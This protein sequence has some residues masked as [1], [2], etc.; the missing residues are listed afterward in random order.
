MQQTVS[1]QDSQYGKM[2]QELSA[3]TEAKISRPSSKRSQAS[4]KKEYMFLDL[5]S[6][7]QGGAWSA[8]VGVL[9]GGSMT[10]NTGECPSVVVEST[11]SQIL[12][13]NAPRR[14]ALSVKACEGILRRSRKRG[15]D[16][17]TMLLTALEQ[18]IARGQNDTDG[19]T[20]L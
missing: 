7:E 13:E 18:Q 14:Y 9:P 3:A 17:P 10:L 11:L 12:V 16:L 20:I 4:A 6:G 1:I 8:M 19:E 2:S 5:R 15:K